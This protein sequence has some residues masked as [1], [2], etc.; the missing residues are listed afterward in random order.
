MSKPITPEAKDALQ[1]ALRTTQ[2][3]F[4][5]LNRAVNKFGAD[6]SEENLK[7]AYAALTK[8]LGASQ[9]RAQL[10][11]Q[12]AGTVSV[13]F[14]SNEPIPAEDERYV[15]TWFPYGRNPEPTPQL[16]SAVT[17][18]SKELIAR[19]HSANKRQTV[20]DVGG[21]FTKDF[22]A[23]IAVEGPPPSVNVDD[24]DIEAPDAPPERQFANLDDA[25][26]YD[27]DFI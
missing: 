9:A 15:V 4:E 6:I 7:R 21:R 18:K 22:K 26:L 16:P 25:L 3:G 5:E 1:K 10:D 14:D 17:D 23:G 24:S 8:A 19:A 2:R 12:I 13:D 20:A 27:A 11:L